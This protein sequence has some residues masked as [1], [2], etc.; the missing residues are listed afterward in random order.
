MA[1]EVILV[2]EDETDILELI[3]YNLER[4]GYQVLTAE[5]GEEGLATATKKVVDLVLLDLMLPGLDGIEVCRRLKTAESTRGI[6][7]LMVTAKG[8]DSDIVTGLE[9]GADD[10]VTKPFSPKVLLARIR[11]LLRRKSLRLTPTSEGERFSIHGIVIDQG[12]HE[13]TYQGNPIPLSA[14]E[15]SILEFLARNP[16]WVFSRNKIIDGVKGKDY[17]VT[18]RSVDVQILG[19]RKKLGEAGDLIETIRGVGYRFRPEE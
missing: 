16:G 3:R 17:P 11:T 2:V 18:E 10:Y 19:L 14:T 8:E 1:K 6:P 15:F 12:R 9:I 7:V 13:V 4:E 5:T